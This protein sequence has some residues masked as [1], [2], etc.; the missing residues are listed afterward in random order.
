[1]VLNAKCHQLVRYL[2]FGAQSVK[3]VN[4]VL[5][6]SFFFFL[7][8]GAGYLFR[9][10]FSEAQALVEAQDDWCDAAEKLHSKHHSIRLESRF[11]EDLE[12]E[13]LTGLLRGDVR[14]NVHCYEVC[15]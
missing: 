6:S 7:G 12:N 10:R 2:F 14:L 13:S 4:F 3:G 9:K 8:M 11:P 15:I 1:M 5:I